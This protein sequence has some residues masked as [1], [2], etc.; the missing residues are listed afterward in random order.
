MT[1]NNTPK[2]GFYLNSNNPIPLYDMFPFLKANGRFSSDYCG[3]KVDSAVVD[4]SKKCMRF[5]LTLAEPAPPYEIR[6]MENMIAQQF[7]LDSVS[8]TAYYYRAAVAAKP[9]IPASSNSVP[10][11]HKKNAVIMGTN[12]K[13]IVTPISEVTLELGKVKIM[14]KVC[15]I[16]SKRLE[17]RGAWI[18]G[19]DLTDY[20]GTL[21]V[22]KFMP[23]E[24]ASGVIDKI[25]NGMWLTV[26]GKLNLSKY[27]EDLT[28]EP[29]GIVT[30]TKD[31]RTDT[32]AEKRVELHLHTKMSALD[33]LTD[34]TEVIKR[35]SKWGHPAIAITDHGVVHSFPEASAAAARMGVDEKIKVI[36]GVEGYFVND[37]DY[38][39]AVHKS[40]ELN[41]DNGDLSG[42][43]VIFDIETT[44]LSPVDDAITEICAILVRGGEELARFE[45]LVNPGK[46]IPPAITAMTGI[47]DADVLGAPSQCDA[48]KS[49][50]AFAKDR[51]L[52]AHNAAFD[53]GFVYE[54]CHNHGIAYHP[55]F[56]DTLTIARTLFPRL[57]SHKLD[58]L[59]KRFGYTDF[60]HHRAG[61]DAMAT[62]FIFNALLDT[63]KA[64]SVTEITQIN[65]HLAKLAGDLPKKGRGRNNHIILLAKNNAGLR[66]LYKLITISHLHHFDRHPIILKSVLTQYRDG[67]IVGSACEAGELFIAIADRRGELAI[68]Q[69]ADFY[70]YLEIQPICNNTFMLYESKPKATGIEDLRNFNRR[71]VKLGKTLG[72][73]VVATG[74]VHFLDPEHEI[75]RH[76]LL[77]SKNYDNADSDLPIFF[78]T[79]AEMLNEF[80]Y[81][82]EETSHEVVVTNTR[83]IAEMCDVVSPLPPAKTLFPPAL[84]GSAEEL[85][86]LVNSNLKRLYGDNPPEIV[87]NRLE[88]ELGGIL[89][90]GYDVIYMTAQKLVEESMKNGYLVGSRGS[91]GSSFVAFLAG[92]TE[93]NALPAHYRCPQCKHC[94]FENSTARGCGA[95]MPDARC[96]ICG[97]MYLKD[98]FN[99]PFETFLG[100][101]GDKVPDID[102]NFSGEYQSH[103][104]RQTMELFGAEHVYRAG[105]IGTIAEKTAIGYVKKY[106]ETKETV[107]T[108]AEE[109]RLA[110]G[111]VGVKRTT[112]RHPGGLVIIPQDTV[113]TDFCPAQHPADS[114][115]ANIITTHFD[116]H[117]ME[118]NLIKLDALGHDDPTMIRQLEDMTGINAMEIRLDDPDT[119]SIFTSPLKLGLPE[120]DDII[121]STGTIGVP[122][123]GTQFTRQMLSDTNPRDF[124]TL[125]RLSGFLHGTDVWLGNAK[126]IIKTGKASVSETISCRDDIMLFLIS[127]GLDDR[128]AFKISESV[129]KGKGLPD[130]TEFEMKKHGVPLWYIESCK[131]IKY[132]FPKAHAVAYV[133]MAFRIAWFKVNKP[134][135]FYSAYFYRRSQKDAFDAECMTQGIHIVLSKIREIKKLP[136]IKGK[137]E[138]LLTTLEAC[139]EFYMRGY[140]F[141]RLDLYDSDPVR[142][143][144]ADENKLRPPLI[145]ISG[146]GETAA[147][148]VADNRAGNDFI[149]IDDISAACVKLTKTNLEQLKALGAL[150]NL[151]DS[152]QLSLF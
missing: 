50:L 12:P 150:R 124:D 134:L 141:A 52:V 7:G 109:R 35:A 26:S 137:D 42:E 38:Y 86:I 93:V 22:S 10:L 59:A 24:A 68:R 84:E 37:V 117:C 130:G 55:Y 126:E 120:D 78:R 47:K 149:S 131:K 152:S 147:Y 23:D 67:L 58:T 148:D 122:E 46:P 54:T 102:L 113:I 125:V 70:D 28:L 71:I 1:L 98:G 74:D 63:L 91:V 140:E 136:D 128:Y 103:A 144:I 107:T 40:Y 60:T 21:H 45:T 94:D 25:K 132:L 101:D 139:Y 83:L 90:R 127:K 133:M 61:S 11:S 138:D 92:I 116:Y 9:D 89:E 33:A 108:K 73:P 114:K 72:K 115:E 142:F 57:K 118:D 146:L 8:I 143:L 88:A 6:T 64:Q 39:K 48:V 53:V 41:V 66:N 82:G 104:H 29:T 106:L 14:G 16:S 44:G 111:C 123:F 77:T 110:R 119:I 129:R 13:G 81:L 135:E 105:T 36:Y 85:N 3:A 2:G 151:P 95:D 75:H 30:A 99:I 100:F 5:N 79:T 31:S 80:S 49:L 112:G 62:V 51:P 20:T 69:I 87:T 56:I 4:E 121:G 96:P 34:V 97:T 43:F 17:N 18:L 15:D 145:A 32:A 76:I 65:P 19:F 27:N